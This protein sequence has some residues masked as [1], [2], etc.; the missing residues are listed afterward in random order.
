[1][2]LPENRDKFGMLRDALMEW[3]KDGDLPSARSIGMRLKQIKGRVVGGLVMKAKNHSN[4]QYWSAV[5]ANGGGTKGTK[6]TFSTYAGENNPSGGET[7]NGYIYPPVASTSP[8]SPSSPTST[9]GDDT[10]G[11]F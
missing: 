11:W 8:S 4:T 6:G 2:S 3:S 1:M 9:D 5:P 10:S 7:S